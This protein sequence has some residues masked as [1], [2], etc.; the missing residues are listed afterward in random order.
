[1]CFSATASFVAAGLT[2]AL[3]LAALRRSTRLSELPLAAMPLIFAMQQL[4]E[5]LLWLSLQ[6]VPGGGPESSM[7]TLLF[8]I[9]AQVLWPV[10]APIAVILIEPDRARRRFMSACLAIGIGVAAY[11]SWIILTRPHGAAIEDGHIVYLTAYD[12]PRLLGLAYLAATGIPLLA[13][14]QRPVAILGAIVT[15]GSAAAYLFYS[16]AFVSVW[17]FFAATASLVIVFYFERS[18]RRSIALAA[19]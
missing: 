14:S 3:G 10:Y 9:T 16:D 13:S 2:G 17:C 19:G 5:G 6:Q 7:L 4:E 1:M 18:Y 15:V 11:L 8:L 12:H